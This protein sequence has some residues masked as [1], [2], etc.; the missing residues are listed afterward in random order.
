MTPM[1]RYDSRLVRQHRKN[2]GMT[3]EAVAK[4]ARLSVR[5]IRGIEAGAAPN[6]RTLARLAHALRL[7]VDAFFVVK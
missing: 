6:V 5:G 3:V 7:G 1:I 4:K 2:L